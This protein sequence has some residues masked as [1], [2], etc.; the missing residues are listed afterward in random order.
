VEIW[1]KVI[2]LS[3]GGIFGVNARY[4]LGAWINR[5]ASPQFPWATVIIN[6]TGSFLIGLLTVMLT[7]WMP[8]PNIRLMVITRFLGGY[9]TFSTFENDA[10][11][12]WER[13]E[14]ILMAA[15]LIGSVT[16]GFAAIVLGTAL[17]RGLTEPVIDRAASGSQSVEAVAAEQL[18]PARTNDDQSMAVNVDTVGE[19]GGHRS[20]NEGSE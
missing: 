3:V 6:V 7:R 1:N 10:L 4:W 2:V 16:V 18:H 20:T 17:A 9:T 13:G 14:G 11:T 19:V 15:N 12:L 8:H 5:W